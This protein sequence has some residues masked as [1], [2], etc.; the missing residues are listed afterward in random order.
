MINSVFFTIAIILMAIITFSVRYVFFTNSVKI[1]L[2]NRIK[3]ILL[4]TAPCILT[5]MTVPILF[6]DI[7]HTKETLSIFSSSY[8]LA[9]VCA[10]I[11]SL[12]IE[13]T[14]LVIMLS[15]VVF[16]GIRYI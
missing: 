8:F 10:I 6:Q 12:L 4:F 9:G 16:Y 13:N 5:A 1:Q 11:F 7:L 15:M 14:L 2:N 3:T